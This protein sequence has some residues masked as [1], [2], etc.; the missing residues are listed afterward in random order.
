MPAFGW[1]RQRSFFFRKERKASLLNSDIVLALFV[2][3]TMIKF[4]TYDG[5]SLHTTASLAEQHHI[6]ILDSLCPRRSGI[7]LPNAILG[8]LA[9]FSKLPPL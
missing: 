4:F 6:L 7:F 8:T 1:K 5:N 3:H 9:G 2:L